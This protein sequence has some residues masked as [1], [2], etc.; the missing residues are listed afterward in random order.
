MFLPAWYQHV[1]WK[2]Q[3]PP[4]RRRR[5]RLADRPPSFVPRLEALEDRLAPAAFIVTSTAD[6]GTAGTLRWAITQA[7]ADTDFSS[8]I[9]FNIASSGV[10]TIQ[11]GSSSSYPGQPLP[12]ITHSV[13]IDGT[14]EGGYSG[15]PLIV[16]DGTQ[17]GSGSNGLTLQAGNSTVKGLAIGD[18]SASG[19]ELTGFSGAVITADYLGTNAAG[20]A[21][22][23]NGNGVEIDSGA[24]GTIGGTAAGAGN[25]ISG[26]TNYGVWIT[27]TNSDGQ[28]QGNKIGTTSDGTTRLGNNTG[29]FIAGGA[30]G[31]IIGGTAATGGAGN[32]IS[33]NGNGVEISGAGTDGNFVVGNLIG[34]NAAGSPGLGNGNGVVIESGANHNLIGAPV[35]FFGGGNTISG[36]TNFGVWITGASSDTQV[37]GN[38]IGTTPDG[39]TAL[40]NGFGVVIDTGAHNNLIG[41]TAAGAGNTISGNGGAGVEISFA[42]L[43]LVQGNL[44]GT[45]DG[46][47]VA[48]IEAFLNT[49][50]GTA[51]GA[52]NTISGN[53]HEGVLIS[54]RGATGNLVQGNKIG[55]N[56]AGTAALANDFGV[57]IQARASSNTIGG[58]AVGAG[59]IISGNTRYGV[60]INNPGTTGNLVQGN[61]IGINAAGTGALANGAG[62][63]IIN[64][65][66]GN[67]IGGTAAGNIIASNLGAG[68]QVGANGADSGTVGNLILAN[69]IFGNGGLGIDL[70]GTGVPLQNSPGG[71]HTGPNDL[72][73]YP[74]LN[75]YVIPGTLSG[76]L[77][78]TPQGTFHL[79]FF[80]N[81]TADP[82]GH[83]QGRHLLG[84]LAVATGASGDGFFTFSYTPIPGE[85]FLTATAT[86]INADGTLGETSEFSASVNGALLSASG[87]VSVTATEAVPFTEVVANFT[88]GAPVSAAAGY[89][90]LI[91]W[92]DGSSS[93]GTIL[94]TAVGFG[95]LGSHSYAEE[96]SDP[97]TVTVLDSISDSASA[98][99]TSSVAD[100]R[101]TAIPKTVNFTEATAGAQVVA[102]FV[103]PDLKAFSGQFTAAIS[104]G[105]GTPSSPGTVVADGSSFD[106]NGTHAYAS[107]GSYPITV[108]IN[109]L[110]TS[111]MANSTAVVSPPALIGTPRG[112]SVFGNLSFSGVV[113]TFT[114]P[115][116]RTNPAGYQATIYWPDNG[117]TSVVTPTG[118]SPFKVSGSHVFSAFA[119]TLTLKVVVVDLQ[120]PGRSVTILSRVADPPASEM[121]QIY[122]T[123]LYADLLQRPPDD[124]SL[125]YWVGLL[126]QGVSREQVTAGIVASPEYKSIEVRQL[127]TTLLHRNADPA[128]LQAFTSFLLLGG[129]VEQVE[130]L[131]AASSEYY[132]VR[133]GG[134]N[135]GFLTALYQDGLNRALDPTGQAAFSQALAQGVS[136]HDVATA[137][138]ASDE[139][140]R[141]LVSGYYSRFLHRDADPSGLTAF[142]SALRQG[143]RDEAVVAAITASDEYFAGLQLPLG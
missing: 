52:G 115:D 34:T 124:G 28:V 107:K 19:I 45:N 70:G 78:S 119:G 66:S 72:Q 106:V 41:G 1:T 136:R 88:V 55:T 46:T 112:I 35:L 130:A 53:T 27:G 39:T 132:Q 65:A 31:N 79:E 86:S 102:S 129:T 142:S 15:T 26:N 84:T 23:A 87:T 116:P 57:V 103:D 40:G 82:S 11:V 7:N 120:T 133:G 94:S 143:L 38:K 47:G 74:V 81:A 22:P 25:T 29:V 134:T 43:N 30:S 118:S 93:V 14:T 98:S 141:D 109:D 48:L 68:V 135:A 64:G 12:A 51:A 20:T 114:D 123:Q 108:T 90:A 37:Q 80:A 95:V 36:N 83:G 97:V 56:A 44:I 140:E 139:Y 91:A 18:F 62:V 32:T 54:G 101:L 13:T 71:P 6:D 137:L 69:A 75:P 105:D 49:I 121:N 42:Q 131:L 59:N 99:G 113:A 63:V 127:Y 76:T 77:N 126:N 92:G 138:F 10:Q 2:F 5:R 4:D 96:G 61:K 3:R 110:A 17:A 67:T 117:T 50:G 128:G 122:A 104:W 111:T 21:A 24:S 8:V 89:T 9:N 33:G 16:L 73:N 100:A 125:A 60:F 58:T 85:P